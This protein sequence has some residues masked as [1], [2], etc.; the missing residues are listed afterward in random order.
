M[1]CEKSFRTDTRYAD[2]CSELD[3]GQTAAAAGGV[4]KE[5]NV[6]CVKNCEVISRKFAYDK[7]RVR[8]RK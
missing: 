8:K 5:T 3:L 2:R 1:G 7:G 6:I 4:V